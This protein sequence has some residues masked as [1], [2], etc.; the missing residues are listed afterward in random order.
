[1]I[2]LR[3]GKKRKLQY[4][5]PIRRDEREKKKGLG[6]IGSWGLAG[7]GWGLGFGGWE[8]LIGGWEFPLSGIR[9]CFLRFY[10]YVYVYVHGYRL[11]NKCARRTFV[12]SFVHTWRATSAA[13]LEPWWTTTP[14][15]S[16]RERDDES[17]TI[18]RDAA[19]SLW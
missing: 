10:I 15:A 8:G 3:R 5:N 7:G 9:L 1:M 19:S 11:Q 18:T 4:S 13:A 12:R 2:G 6:G 17:A 14:H 16:T